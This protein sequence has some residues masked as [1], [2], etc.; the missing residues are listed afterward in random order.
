[1]GD[2][3]TAKPIVR[4]VGR[5]VVASSKDVAAYFGKRHDH[6]LRDI[7]TL[8]SE[9]PSCAPN[10]GATSETVVMPRGGTRQVRSFDMTRDDFTLLAMGFTGAKALKATPARS[11]RPTV[12]SSTREGPCSAGQRL[13]VSIS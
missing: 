4:T 3:V 11:T 8:I 13:P 10:F 2:L 9:A 6:V 7:D 1:M 12:R 5:F